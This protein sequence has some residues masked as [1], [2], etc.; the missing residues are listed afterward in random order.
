MNNPL[1]KIRF[2]A[3]GVLIKFARKLKAERPKSPI[4]RDSKSLFSKE[5]KIPVFISS[6]FTIIAIY[7]M[8][9][10]GFATN[11]KTMLAAAIF[12][13]GSAVFFIIYTKSREKH[14]KR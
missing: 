11:C 10:M 7:C 13:T 4:V 14:I 12:V 5:I 1:E 8:F 6:A 3:I 2:W 9:V